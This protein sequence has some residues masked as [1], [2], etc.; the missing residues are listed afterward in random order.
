MQDATELD[1]TSS[2]SNFASDPDVEVINDRYSPRDYQSEKPVYVPNPYLKAASQYGGSNK[3]KSDT[4]KS[5]TRSDPEANDSL[6]Y[7]VNPLGLTPGDNPEFPPLTGH[8]ISNTVPQITEAQY[9][10]AVVSEEV[11]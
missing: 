7:H 2:R 11:Y 3:S 10:A 1:L 5:K 8:H 9:S 4:R 6:S